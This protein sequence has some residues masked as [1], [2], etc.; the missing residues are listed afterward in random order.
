M[1]GRGAWVFVGVVLLLL[2]GCAR[3]VERPQSTAPPKPSSPSAEATQAIAGLWVP[4]DRASSGEL[5]SVYFSSDGTVVVSLTTTHPVDSPIP[6]REKPTREVT[7]TADFPGRWLEAGSGDVRLKA[8]YMA[9]VNGKRAVGSITTYRYSRSGD[10][11]VL[12]WVA[13]TPPSFYRHGPGFASMKGDSW[14][15]DSHGSV[16]LVLQH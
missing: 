4:A 13:G 12:S 6:P 2:I 3:P 16:R 11:L 14:I 10:S 8:D 5:D 7:R 9:T 1:R 15:T